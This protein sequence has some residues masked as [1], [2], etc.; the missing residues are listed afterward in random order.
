MALQMQIR[1]KLNAL[2]RLAPYMNGDKK[3]IVLKAFIESQFGYCPLLWMYHS[4]SLNDKIHWILEGT[5]RITY[6]GKSSYFQR[7][8]EKKN[9]YTLHHRN[10]KI[11]ATGTYIFLQGLS[12]PLMNKIFVER[13]NS[14]S[15]RWNS[16]PSRGRVSELW[17]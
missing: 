3:L 16:V 17:R 11:L 13:N 15:F 1:Q 9:S 7:L 6:N 8:L 4:R 5:L 14:Y 12:P 2:A 10:I